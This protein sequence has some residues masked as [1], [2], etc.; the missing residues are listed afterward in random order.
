M[1]LMKT[2]FFEIITVIDGRSHI[3]VVADVITRV[4][5]GITTILADA[6]TM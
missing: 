1:W 4:A 5:D 2:T 6:I 3:Y